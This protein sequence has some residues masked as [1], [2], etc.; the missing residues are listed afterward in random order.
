MK[1]AYLI[2]FSCF[3]SCGGPSKSET[4]DTATVDTSSQMSTDEVV[5]TETANVKLIQKNQFKKW[6]FTV[7]EGLLKCEGGNVT[8]KAN[9]VLYGVNGSGATYAKS[10]GGRD[11]KDI[12]AVDEKATKELIDVGVPRKNA[13]SYMDVGEVLEFGRTLCK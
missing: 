10:H 3:L 8:F 12:W 1:K 4:N 11:M 7:G 2:V 6:P 5:V 13:T 9:G